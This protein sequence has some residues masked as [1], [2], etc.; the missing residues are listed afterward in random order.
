MAKRKAKKK[1]AAKA[2]PATQAAKKP[3]PK[4]PAPKKPA[5]K[6]RAPAKKRA[7]RKQLPAPPETPLLAEHS[8]VD[9]GWEI[10]S[11]RGLPLVEQVIAHLAGTGTP[12]TG[13]APEVLATLALPGGKPLPPSLRRFLAFDAH[14]LHA[15]EGD[16][17]RL[18]FHTFRELVRHELDETAADLYDEVADLLPG[19]CLLL[20]GG[21]TKRRFMYVGAPDAHGEYPVLEI[22]PD[23][24]P[25]V[26]LAYPGLDVYLADGTTAHLLGDPF[27]GPYGAAMLDQAERN[28]HGFKK[29]TG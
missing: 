16:P 10:E 11:P 23:D 13:L 8:V 3:A 22:D 6:K 26:G 19:H 29:L 14:Y 9:Q 2:K 24:L 27:E 12:H 25:G 20:P 18:V 5:P 28:L 21:E 15:L 1:P 7:P 17:P 4:K